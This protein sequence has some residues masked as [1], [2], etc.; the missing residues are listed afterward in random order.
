MKK[1]TGYILL[2]T[3]LMTIHPLH[4]E[5]NTAKKDRTPTYHI[6]ADINMKSTVSYQYDK[7]MIMKYVYPQLTTETADDYIDRFNTDVLAIIKE[8]TDEFQQ[9]VK[10]NESTLK[11]L[12][13]SLSKENN[14]LQ[15]DYDS[16]SV[17]SGDNYIMSVRFSVSGMIIGM[18]HP[19]HYYRVFNYNLDTGEQIELNQLFKPDADYLAVLSN[20]TRG[21]LEKRLTEKDM[22]SEG[23]APKPENFKVWNIKPNGL[24]ITFNEYQVAP[25]VEGAQTVLVPYNIIK[26]ILADNAV[27]A[28]CLK[29]R[30]SCANSNLLTG[31]FIDEAALSSKKIYAMKEEQTDNPRSFGE[32][33]KKLLGYPLSLIHRT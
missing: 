33:A 29:H 2:S 23:T 11:L 7:K 4:A 20:Y 6:Y 13:K 9:K 3:A 5:E 24:L 27:I 1:L 18:A 32:T 21:E 31:G 15:V 12:P 30:K 25:Y 8:I 14:T 26:P 19:Y 28:G 16:S 10:D 22:V 17:E